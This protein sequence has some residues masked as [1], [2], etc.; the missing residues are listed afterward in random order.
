MRN[1]VYIPV[2]V[3]CTAYARRELLFA[4]LDNRERFVYCDTDSLHLLGTE[5][6][7]NIP[8]HDKELCHWKV[9]GTFTRAKHLRAKAYVWDL[10]GKFS[11]T[12]AGMPD[13]V[14]ALVT[15]D[16]FEYGFTNAFTDKDG[17]TK[18]CPLFAK[19]MPK[20]VPG[21]VVLLDS[22]YQLHA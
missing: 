6:P 5:Q 14:K 7:N 17:N 15:W 13:D 20:T 4:I 2:G 9:E 1:P 12:C 11:V 21:G 18:I 16:N 10:N 8:I 3:F 22:V 19:L